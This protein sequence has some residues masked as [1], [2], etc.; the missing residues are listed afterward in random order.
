MRPIIGI[1]FLGIGD[2]RGRVE[3]VLNEPATPEVIDALLIAGGRDNAEGVEVDGAFDD[4]CGFGG[5]I[6]GSGRGRR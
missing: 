3:V 5:F 4:V 2:E 1:R 6:L